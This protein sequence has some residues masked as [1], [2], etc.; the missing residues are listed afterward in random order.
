MLMI[1]YRGVALL[2][3]MFVVGCDEPPAILD[4]PATAVIVVSGLPEIWR[5]AAVTL[6]EGDG[7]DLEVAASLVPAHGITHVVAGWHS[8]AVRSVEERPGGRVVIAR[9]F[10]FGASGSAPEQWTVSQFQPTAEAEVVSVST[11]PA[12]RSTEWLSL[13]LVLS[14]IEISYSEGRAAEAVSAYVDPNVVHHGVEPAVGS[15]ALL[16]FMQ[17]PQGRRSEHEV[18]VVAVQNDMIATVSHIGAGADETTA[19]DFFRVQNGLIAEHWEILE[20]VS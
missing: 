7:V 12:A 16:A 20:P 9:I 2:C 14:F 15:D 8:I 11:D 5:A 4:D 13:D 3:A 18:I 10:R 6:T 19:F 1:R 17:S